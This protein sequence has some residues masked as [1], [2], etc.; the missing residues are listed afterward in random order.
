MF[1]AFLIYPTLLTLPNRIHAQVFQGGGLQEGID[2]AQNIQ[3]VSQSELQPFILNAISAVMNILGLLAAVS[4]IAC[5]VL[6]IISIGN[7]QMAGKAKKG[8]L[9]SIVGLLLILFAKAII[10]LIQQLG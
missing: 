10:G 8:V 2:A 4:I 9:Y 3:G 7:E 5:G 6:L 1:T